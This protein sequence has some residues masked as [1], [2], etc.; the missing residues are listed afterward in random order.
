MNYVREKKSAAIK[1]SV[2]SF[3]IFSPSAQHFNSNTAIRSWKKR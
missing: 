3:Y 2:I 1:H